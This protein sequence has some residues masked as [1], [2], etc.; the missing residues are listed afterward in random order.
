MSFFIY[1]KTETDHLARRDKKMAAVIERYG[2]PERKV[3]P[4]LFEALV[5]SIIAQQISSKAAATV[6]QRLREL[7]GIIS[8]ES[9]IRIAEREIQQCGM[10][11]KKAGYIK[12]AARTILNKT[13]ALDDFPALD[14]ETIIT[15]LTALPGIGRWTAEMLLLHSLQ[16]PNVFSYD[17][18]VIRRNLMSL[19]DLSVLTKSDFAKYRDLYSPYCSVAMIYLW[20]L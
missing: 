2:M 3:T 15:Q 17:D 16:R 12:S 11:L 7:C 9:I 8:P 6:T 13:I 20:K 19:H 18:L 14:D 10:T 4:D 5:A 1:G